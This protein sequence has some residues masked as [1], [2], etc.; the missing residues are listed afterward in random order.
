MYQMKISLHKDWKI[1][2]QDEIQKPYF[3]DLLAIVEQEY[4]EYTCFPP[5]D[6]IFSAFDSCDL[7]HLKVVII[8]QDPYHGEGVISIG[9]SMM[10]WIR[11]LCP[12]QVI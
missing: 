5:Q 6:L 8:G 3:N 1:L 7:T 11:F 12:T 9:K 2:L 10:I 4:Q